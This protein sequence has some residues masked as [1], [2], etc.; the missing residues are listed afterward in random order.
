MVSVNIAKL[1]VIALFSLEL[2]SCKEQS[3][4][5]LD[6]SDTAPKS[7]NIQNIRE[8][9]RTAVGTQANKKL[10]KLALRGLLSRLN[11]FRWS[12]S[13]AAKKKLLKSNLS[14][15]QNNTKT[16]PNVLTYTKS[17]L[18]IN[19]TSTS[20]ILASPTNSSAAN[21]SQSK[22]ATSLQEKEFNIDLTNNK[23]QKKNS[24][25]SGFI[26]RLNPFKYYKKGLI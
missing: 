10:E 22:N 7:Q 16:Y 18:I 4:L 8:S 1:C 6:L 17:G 12:R 20:T 3:G 24:W 15:S 2:A 26:S 5:L 11:P 9:N 19:G 25:I 23:K 21:P 14:T 13:R